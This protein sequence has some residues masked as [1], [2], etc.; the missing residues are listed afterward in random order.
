MTVE[1]IHEE[2]GDDIHVKNDDVIS[3][4]P[5]AYEIEIEIEKLR[6]TKEMELA[7]LIKR[8]WWFYAYAILGMVFC[9]GLIYS[10]SSIGLLWAMLVFLLLFTIYRQYVETKERTIDEIENEIRGYDD[11]SESQLAELYVMAVKY[12]EIL[13]YIKR[14]TSLDRVLMKR[15]A[16][17][18]Y[19]VSTRIEKYR[20]IAK[21]KKL[22]GLKT[23]E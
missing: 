7:T 17:F 14:A 8:R 9:A 2:V 20:N 22:F 11:V 4:P 10:Y 18:L 1:N 21:A 13:A 12:P 3:A 5:T 6:Q 15:E 16:K 19:H 23:F